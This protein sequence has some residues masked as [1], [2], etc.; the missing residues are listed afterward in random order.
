M[1]SVLDKV[2]SSPWA[3]TL[4]QGFIVDALASIGLGLG[5]LLATGDL[6]SPVFW[7]AVGLLVAKS[8]LTSI[9]S[10][11]TRLKPASDRLD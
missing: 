11:L 9:T 8:F 2:A 3:R 1:V 6:T 10:W 4:W 7:T 5:T